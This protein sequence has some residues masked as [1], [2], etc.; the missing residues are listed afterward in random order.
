MQTIASILETLVRSLGRWG[1]AP[2]LGRSGAVAL[3]TAVCAPVL[4]MIAGF[5]ADFGYASYVNQRLA[6]ATDAAALSAVSQTVATAAGG[7]GNLAYLQSAGVKYFNA[8]T[9][10]LSIP[11]GIGFNLSVI[12]DGSGGVIAT[13]TYNAAV[14]TTFSG[15]IGMSTIPVAGNA[16][17]TAKPVVYVNYYILVDT[18]QSMGIAATASDMAALYNL[19]VS[20]NNGSGGEAG[21]VFGCHVRAP[22]HVPDDGVLQSVSNEQ[23]AHSNNITLRIDSAVTAI[24]SIISQ[25]QSVAGYNLNI[26]FGLYA[27]QENPNCT[28]PT[29]FQPYITNITPAS[30]GGQIS[31]FRATTSNDYPSLQAAASTI[32]LGDNQKGGIGDSDFPDELNAFATMLTNAGIVANGS[33][34]S[35]TS[36]MNYF[37]IIT[38]G[39]ADVPGWCNGHSHCTSAFNPANCSLLKTRGTV[40]TIYTT[41]NDIWA[42]NNP[43]GN[44]LEGNYAGLVKP[45]K[46]QIGPNLQSCASSSD[47]YFPANEGPEIIAAMQALFARTQPSSARIAQ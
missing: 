33:G 28:F 8:N 25:A 16:K 10:G 23:L 31:Q 1:C 32:D 30:G 12:P 44:V 29:C 17:T 45:F 39:A 7:Y 11:G 13:A 18:S 15:I 34:V 42:N 37:F 3:V 47:Y 19:V 6:R 21:C 40:G 20:N 27:I 22:S 4:V 5:A 38:D 9:A 43:A 46:D 14:P 41:W 24:K 2:R 36:P 35:A 26:G